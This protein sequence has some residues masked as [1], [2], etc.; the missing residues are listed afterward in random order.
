MDLGQQE[1]NN[2]IMKNVLKEVMRFQGTETESE[3]RRL[4][5]EVKEITK[6]KKSKCQSNK[7]I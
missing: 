1:F 6:N 4:C 3:L 7:L 5:Q 2:N